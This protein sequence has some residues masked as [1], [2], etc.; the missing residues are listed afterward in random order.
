MYLNI[1]FFYLKNLLL[2]FS[3]NKI[4][5]FQNIYLYLQSYMYIFL[6]FNNKYLFFQKKSIDYIIY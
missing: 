2:V 3:N 5:N 6:F 4:H 1:I